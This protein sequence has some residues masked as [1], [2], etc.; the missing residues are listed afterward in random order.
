MKPLKKCK[1][2]HI[3]KSFLCKHLGIHNQSLNT[4]SRHFV[5]YWK[6]Q[7]SYNHQTRVWC[8]QN[9]SAWIALAIRLIENIKNISTVLKGLMFPLKKKSI[10]EENNFHSHSEKILN[11]PEWNYVFEHIEN[12][13]LYPIKIPVNC[14]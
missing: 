8:D 3:N 1:T 6:H 7:T 13:K 14:S 11:D 2:I 9:T 12:H 10:P 4:L 5:D